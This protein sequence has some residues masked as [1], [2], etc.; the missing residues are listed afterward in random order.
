MAGRPGRSGGKPKPTA[1]RV[2]EGNP[3]KRPLPIGEPA[4]KGGM[5]KPPG[6]LDVEARAEWK[7]IEAT[8]GA[9][10]L[11][12]PA[13]RAMVTVWCVTWSRWLGAEAQVRKKGTVVLNARTGEPQENPYLKIADKA[14]D[15]LL[16]IAEQYGMTASARVRLAWRPKTKKEA[17][18][19]KWK[20]LLG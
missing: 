19:S 16:R 1:L 10:G 3:A 13:D 12:T 9:A 8:L 17:Q 14:A 18:Q 4:I 20:G 11:I 2:L 6:G 5:P 15:R 7:R